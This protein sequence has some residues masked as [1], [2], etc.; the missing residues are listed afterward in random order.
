M[1][2]Y[3]LAVISFL[4]NFFIMPINK[5]GHDKTGLTLLLAIISIILII[6]GI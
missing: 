3:S 2:G 1:I 6:K 5:R 4:L